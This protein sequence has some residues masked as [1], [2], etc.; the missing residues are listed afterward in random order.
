MELEKQGM[1]GEASDERIHVH[2]TFRGILAWSI[3]AYGS[4]EDR[5]ARLHKE[6]DAW[7]LGMNMYKPL[8]SH[9]SFL[10]SRIA[11]CLVSRK[12]YC[13]KIGSTSSTKVAF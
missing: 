8:S 3:C 2:L 12:Y 6:R 7:G 11:N 10:G 13:N 9:T 5:L 4:R 1:T